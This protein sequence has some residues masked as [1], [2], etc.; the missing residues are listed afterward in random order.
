VDELSFSSYYPQNTNGWLIPAKT[1]MNR[2]IKKVTAQ[3]SQLI[4]EHHAIVDFE[5]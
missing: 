5:R 4:L 2:F 1:Q 3:F